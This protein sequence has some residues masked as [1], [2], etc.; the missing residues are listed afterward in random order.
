MRPILISTRV[1]EERGYSE[2]RSSLAYE[3]VEL[4]AGLGYLPILVPANAGRLPGGPGNGAVDDYFSLEPAAVVLTGGNTVDPRRQTVARGTG[5][6][7]DAEE[8]AATLSSIYPERD[9]T[10]FALIRGALDRG[11]PVLGICRGMQILNCYF[12]GGVSYNRKGHV[13]ADHELVSDNPE[14]SGQMT[15][16]YHNDVIPGAE[17]AE[18]LRSLAHTGDGIIE[19]FYHPEEPILAMQWHPE[20][21]ERSF[22]RA[23]IR[24]FLK[25]ELSL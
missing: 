23:L 17:L 21:Q 14:L 19:A 10:E 2:K 9:E 6:P 25:G 22:D 8:Q 12:G 20:R 15:N 1:T 16:S 18:P 24:A 7:T 13:G 5:T 3:Y 4:F 11:L